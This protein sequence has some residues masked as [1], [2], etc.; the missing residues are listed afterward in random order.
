MGANIAK[1]RIK[2]EEV[3]LLIGRQNRFFFVIEMGE[4]REL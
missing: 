1:K 4:K 2:T 3:K